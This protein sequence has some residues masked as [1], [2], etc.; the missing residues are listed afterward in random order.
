M[1]EGRYNVVRNRVGGPNGP[2]VSQWEVFVPKHTIWYGYDNEGNNTGITE[3]NVMSKSMAYTR[4]LPAHPI[5]GPKKWVKSTEQIGTGFESYTYDSF[6]QKIRIRYSGFNGSEPVASYRD[7]FVY[8]D[9]GNVVAEKHNVPDADASLQSY[10]G[11][12][13]ST[14]DEMGNVIATGYRPGLNPGGE[15]NVTFTEYDQLDRPVAEMNQNSTTERTEYDENSREIRIQNGRSIVEEFGYSDTGEITSEKQNAANPNSAPVLFTYDD[16]GLMT[17]QTSRN[18]HTTFFDRNRKGELTGMRYPGSGFTESFSYFPNSDVSSRRDGEGGAAV[19]SADEFARITNVN[20]RPFQINSL[21]RGNIQRPQ[22]NSQFIYDSANRVSS[23]SNF[24]NGSLIRSHTSGYNHR[25]LLNQVT[26]PNESLGRTFY[27]NGMLRTETV[28]GQ[29]ITYILNNR[30][31]L[32]QI[33]TPH[34]TT[35]FTYDDYNRLREKSQSNGVTERTFYHP[36][37]GEESFT[38]ILQNS[39]LNRVI[40]YQYDGNL[41]IVS[42]TETVG[43]VVKAYVYGYDEND[44]LTSETG[45]GFGITYAYDANGNRTQKTMTRQLPSGGSQLTAD[46][47][48]YGLGDRLVRRT[49]TIDSGPAVETEYSHDHDGRVVRIRDIGGSPLTDFRF[50]Y[51]FEDNLLEVRNGA[52]QVLEQNTFG[53]L[54]ARIGGRV[55]GQQARIINDEF[56]PVGT[57]RAFTVNEGTATA[58]RRILPKVWD[59]SSSGGVRYT[60]GDDVHAHLFSTSVGAIIEHPEMDSF[61][62]LVDPNATNPSRSFLANTGAMGTQLPGGQRLVYIGHRVYDPDLGRFLTRDCEQDGPNWYVYGG[63]NP[64]MMHD[65]SGQIFGFELVAIIFKQSWF[66]KVLKK[67]IIAYKKKKATHVSLGTI[68]KKILAKR[69]SMHVSQGLQKVEKSVFGTDWLKK[70][71]KKMYSYMQAYKFASGMI[72]AANLGGKYA[73][74][75]LETQLA[76]TITDTVTGIAAKD[77]NTPFKKYIEQVFSSKTYENVKEPSLS[78]KWVWKQVNSA[79]MGHFAEWAHLKSSKLHLGKK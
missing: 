72:D 55:D 58:Y 15:F 20:Y 52:N 13:Y 51:D 46:T 14:F 45:P 37:H 30:G 10:V 16:L 1:S 78:S 67:A 61:G 48:L 76:N 9:R 7:L 5:W 39:V 38:E 21:S 71:L 56:G 65:P 31:M 77:L 42:K 27:S 50:D 47:Y 41:N 17:A 40:A 57:A 60:H 3:Q 24:A 69:I 33:L 28:N 12:N 63:N 66:K 44:Q 25:N 62:N 74:M 4:P 36:I 2:I 22:R 8:D 19:R 64:V 49:R 35:T 23:M 70:N 18:G 26:G 54:G 6:G 59:W 29:T 32:G 68:G 75:H 11:W 79:K 43:G 73:Q 53:P 34:G